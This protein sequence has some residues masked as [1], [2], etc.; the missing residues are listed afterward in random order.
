VNNKART[1]FREG[2]EV[3]IVFFLSIVSI[4]FLFQNQERKIGKKRSYKTITSSN[5]ISTK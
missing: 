3:E 5:A 4:M 1:R 2:V